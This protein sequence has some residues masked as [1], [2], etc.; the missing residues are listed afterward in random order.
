MQGRDDVLKE[1]EKKF[2]LVALTLRISITGEIRTLHNLQSFDVLLL[3]STDSHNTLDHCCL[4]HSRCGVG[5]EVES[6]PWGKDL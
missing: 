4:D 3:V 1:T 2:N 5:H 6:M